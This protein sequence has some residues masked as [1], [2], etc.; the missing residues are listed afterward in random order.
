MG[1]RRSNAC[2]RGDAIVRAMVSTWTHRCKKM[3]E[4]NSMAMHGRG[5]SMIEVSM[6]LKFGNEASVCT[7]C[8]MYWNKTAPVGE[9]RTEDAFCSDCEILVNE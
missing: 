6:L 7:I 9:W 5:V 2:A 1:I 3:A 8:R 4:V